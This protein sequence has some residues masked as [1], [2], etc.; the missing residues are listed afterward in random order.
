MPWAFLGQAHHALAL[1]PAASSDSNIRLFRK[2]SI[3][4]FKKIA[5]P[6]T[7]NSRS[8]ILFRFDSPLIEARGPHRPFGPCEI[9]LSKY[10]RAPTLLLSAIEPGC[11]DIPRRADRKSSLHI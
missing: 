9:H 1:A 11:V 10:R 7:Q 6:A 4:I 2:K 5:W 8:A 3:Q